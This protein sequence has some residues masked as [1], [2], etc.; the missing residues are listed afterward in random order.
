MPALREAKPEYWTDQI[1]P[2]FD[3]FAER[4]LST[5]KER[6][7][8]TKRSVEIIFRVLAGPA[9]QEARRRLLAMGITKVLGTYYSTCLTPL[10]QHAPARPSGRIM[11]RIDHLVPG[12]M[13]SMWETEFP[14]RHPGYNAWTAIVGTEEDVRLPFL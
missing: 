3:S 4:D 5:T 9:D 14:G 12:T 10:G 11:K 2:F 13:D 8:V 7:E 1:Q 6:S